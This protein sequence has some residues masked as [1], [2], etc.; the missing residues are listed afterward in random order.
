MNAVLRRLS[1]SAALNI[2]EIGEICGFPFLYS[3]C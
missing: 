3:L 2:C 1:F